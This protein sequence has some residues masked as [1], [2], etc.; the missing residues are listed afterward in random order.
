MTLPCAECVGQKLVFLQ[1]RVGLLQLSVDEQCLFLLSEVELC[2]GKF[3]HDLSLV[4]VEIVELM[5]R[6]DGIFRMAT[7]RCAYGMEQGIFFLIGTLLHKALIDIDSLLV[8]ACL[9]KVGTQY[10]EGA[11][12]IGMKK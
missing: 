5:E 2:P 1:W 6:G 12:V 4:G 9:L 10:G 3:F 7:E 11:L 8:I